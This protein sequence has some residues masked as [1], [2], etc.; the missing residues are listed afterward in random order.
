MGVVC[1]VVDDVDGVDDVDI[2]DET[3]LWMFR[4]AVYIRKKEPSALAK[5]D[6]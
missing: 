4:T 2:V 3:T 1:D 5:L 6:D